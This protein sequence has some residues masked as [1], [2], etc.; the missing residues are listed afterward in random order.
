MEDFTEVTKSK[1]LGFLA[2]YDGHGRKDAAKFTKENL[3]L[4]IK[5]HDGFE[6]DDP[7]KVA[8]AISAGFLHMHE[9]MY[10]VMCNSI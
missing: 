9:E 3:W 8:K 5:T 4:L 7:F 10:M 1:G 6:S 2:V